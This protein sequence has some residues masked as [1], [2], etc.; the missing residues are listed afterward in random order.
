VL[1]SGKS[2]E[3]AEIGTC[4]THRDAVR[5]CALILSALNGLA[6][7]FGVFRW[8]RHEPSRGFWIAIRVGQGAAIL[9]AL[10]T[11]AYYLAGW[12]PS[13]NLFY[14]YALLPPVIGSVAEQLRLVAADHVLTQRD[15]DDAEALGELPAADQQNVVL[16]IVRREMGVM[17]AAAVVVCF[18]ALRAWGTY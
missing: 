18:L 6:G 8:Y 13:D 5:D 11:G 17:A 15:L 3:P 4:V 14:L 9:Y 7:L 1:L 10:M 2:R 16:A 12:G